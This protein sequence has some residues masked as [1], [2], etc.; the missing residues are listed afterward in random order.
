MT[1]RWGILATGNI[2]RTFAEAVATS[3][4]ASLTAV[5]SRDLARA[6]RFADDCSADVL[7]LDYETLISHPEVDAV[8]VATPHTLHADWTIRALA[9]GKHVLCEKP[10]GLNHAEAMAMV[11]A[12]EAGGCF[13]MEAFMYRC[14]PAT[15]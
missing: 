8:Y 11:D 1:L 4:R 9:A 6:T 13:L 7:A 14:H 5:A 3:T 15:F 10:M 12:A 2:A